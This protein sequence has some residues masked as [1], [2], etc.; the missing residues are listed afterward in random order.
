MR[1]ES[2]LRE[3]GENDS[4]DEFTLSFREQIRYAIVNQNPWADLKLR[5]RIRFAL[6]AVA[7]RMTLG[8]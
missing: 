3:L 4:W 1:G 5:G 6:P 8:I 2:L 7:L